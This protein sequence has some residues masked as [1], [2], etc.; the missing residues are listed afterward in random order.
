[1][2]STTR[3]VPVRGSAA[4]SRINQAAPAQIYDHRGEHGQEHGQ[5]N[6]IGAGNEK[7]MVWKWLRNLV[8]GARFGHD[9]TSP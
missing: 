4:H 3:L 8:A 2:R 7:V 1:M 6:P 9:L 5:K